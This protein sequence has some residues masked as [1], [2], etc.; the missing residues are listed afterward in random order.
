MPDSIRILWFAIASRGADSNSFTTLAGERRIE[1]HAKVWPEGFASQIRWSVEDFPKDSFATAIPSTFVRNEGDVLEFDVPDQDTMRMRHFGIPEINSDGTRNPT[2][3]PGDWYEKTLGYRI[4]AHV[5]GS[6]ANG[7]PDVVSP[8]YDVVQD[9]RD[10]VREEYIELL[11][12]RGPGRR[13]TVP[14]RDEFIEWPIADVGENGGD[15][16]LRM[17]RSA[18]QNG[19]DSLNALFIP[20]L[21]RGWQVNVVFRSP[22]H[23]LYHQPGSDVDSWHMYGCAADLQTFPHPAGTDTASVIYKRAFKYWTTLRDLADSLDFQT[24][25]LRR[26]GVGHVHVEREC[27]P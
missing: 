25:S 10:V 9:R 4:T 12:P 18:L 20:P 17:Y 6:A 13:R 15:Y 23:N 24:E 16:D 19:V 11:A 26:G 21:D 5:E 14:R 27:Y 7:A 2:G 1:V 3:R 8:P 22:V